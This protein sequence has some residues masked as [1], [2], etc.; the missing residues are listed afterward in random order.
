MDLMEV[1]SHVTERFASSPASM[2]M[3]L[4]H[5]I[6]GRP[7]PVPLAQQLHRYLHLFEALSLHQQVTTSASWA[8]TAVQWAVPL[9]D[10]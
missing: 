5:H 9:P 1:P 4:Q 6:S 10:G 3:F 7:M 8:G 2:R